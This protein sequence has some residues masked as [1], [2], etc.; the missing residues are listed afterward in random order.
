MHIPASLVAII[1]PSDPIAPPLSPSP[2]DP[3]NQLVEAITPQSPLKIILP[4]PDFPINAVPSL[5]KPK[6]CAPL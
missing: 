5:L 4:D 6:D 3:K 2:V 1:L